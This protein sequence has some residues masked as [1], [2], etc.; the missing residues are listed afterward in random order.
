[1]RLTTILI[2]LINVAYAFAGCTNFPFNWKDR[3]GQDCRQYAKHNWCAGAD[4]YT[5]KDGYSASDVCCTCGGGKRT[6]GDTCTDN[7]AWRDKGNF[8]CEQYNKYP[9]WCSHAWKYAR[10]G[11][12]ATDECCVCKKNGD[13][14]D[15]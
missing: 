3:L 9:Q 12:D 4:S 13:F 14:M 15:E 8:S 11:R 7:V 1:M 5:N 10:N 6:Q 2:L